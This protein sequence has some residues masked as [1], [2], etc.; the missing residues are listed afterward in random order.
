VGSVFLTCELYLHVFACGK[1]FD[2]S[3]NEQIIV[4]E[5]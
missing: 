3:N 5:I 2:S 1:L 4:T